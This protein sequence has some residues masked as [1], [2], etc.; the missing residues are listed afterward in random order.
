MPLITMKRQVTVHLKER[1]LAILTLKAIKE[2]RTIN[3]MVTKILEDTLKG[4]KQ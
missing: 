1:H 4:G 3:N 2:G